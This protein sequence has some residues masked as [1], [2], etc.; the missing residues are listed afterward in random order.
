LGCTNVPGGSGILGL[1]LPRFQGNI[2][3]SQENLKPTVARHATKT[4]LALLLL[5]AAV[6]QTS[7]GQQPTGAGTPITRDTAHAPAS[8]PVSPPVQ[9]TTLKDF[10]WLTGH[11]QGAWGPRIAQQAW[12]SPSAG[13]MLGTFQLAENDKTLVIE[14]FTLIEKPQGI[15]LRMRH[16]TPSLVAWE[17]DG[18]IVL[19]LASTDTKSAVFENPVDGQPKRAVFTRLDADTFVARSEIIPEKGETQVTEITYHRMRETAPAKPKR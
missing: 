6:P 13:A 16:L 15:E 19:N 14:V 4:Q 18:A 3:D 7:P 12:M 10:A 11:W 2:R 9:K 5:V 8:A 17:K 1:S